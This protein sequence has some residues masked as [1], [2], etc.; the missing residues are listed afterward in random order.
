VT[1]RT[2]PNLLIVED[3]D[4]LR[5][6]LQAAAAKCG[7]FGIIDAVQDGSLALE[8]VRMAIQEGGSNAPDFVL[9][10]LSMPVMDGVELIR[11]LKTDRRTAHIPVAVITSSNRP[12]DREDATA[13]GCCAFFNKPVRFDDMLL[14]VRS[15][16]SICGESAPAIA[17]E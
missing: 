15:I 12:N 10:D 8:H 1:P 17:H 7:R 9:T 13:A 6:L 4:R 2:A 11:A 5:E 3:D 14:L 16:P